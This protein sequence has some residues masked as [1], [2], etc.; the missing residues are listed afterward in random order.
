[1]K[2]AFY[3][4]WYADDES[5]QKESDPEGKM[6]SIYAKSTEPFCEDIVEPE[7][8]GRI[9][10]RKDIPTIDLLILL[11][12]FYHAGISVGERNVRQQIRDALEL[13]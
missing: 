7:L 3:H 9:E 10:N 11:Y 13:Q 4:N 1:M 2:V 12:N 8:I 5:R 6:L